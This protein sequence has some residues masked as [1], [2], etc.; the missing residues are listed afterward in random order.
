MLHI[1]FKRAL[2]CTTFLLVTLPVAAQEYKDDIKALNSIYIEAGGNGDGISLN[3]D[4]IIYQQLNF[5]SALRTGIGT[6]FFFLDSEPSPYPIVPVEIAA[7]I[8]PRISYLEL[9][10]GYTKR[11]T[12]EPDL[13]KELYFGR[14]GLRYQKP[15]SGLLVRLGFT[16]YLTKNRD[17]KTD[18]VIMSRFGVSVGY[19]L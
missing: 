19:S 2:Y 18:K 15:R 9:G 5:R 1:I 12:S 3:Y 10:L 7:L 13:E 14:I 11:F 4:R 17:K 16:P 8:G 6:N